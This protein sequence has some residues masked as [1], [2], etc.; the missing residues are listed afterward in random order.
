MGFLN[1]VLKQQKRL[2]ELIG[3]AD[4]LYGERFSAGDKEY[5][6]HQQEITFLQGDNA[7][8]NV[9]FTIPEGTDFYAE[10]LSAFPSYRFVT[11]DEATNGPPERT[12]RP[13]VMAFYE[14]AF[15]P[16]VENDA[17]WGAVDFRFELQET[18]Y[19]GGQAVSRSLQ[20][21]PIPAQ[22][23]FSGPCDYRPGYTI[24]TITAGRFNSFS[25]PTAME[26]PIPLLLNGGSALRMAVNP[27]F[28][29]LREDPAN[30]ANS[31]ARQNEY[32]LTVILEGQRRSYF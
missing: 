31:L 30:P 3:G 29:G 17:E 16:L 1:D 4:K 25:F 12:Y 21:E 26:F 5:Y 19:R 6:A 20:N 8:Q 28:A 9:V 13:C 23:L 27:T 2:D 11:T 24:S 32:K 14:Q 22:L 7:A 10:R 18:F 15:F